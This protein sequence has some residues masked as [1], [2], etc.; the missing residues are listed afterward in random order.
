MLLL[1]ELEVCSASYVSSESFDKSTE[2][3]GAVMRSISWPVA[4][5]NVVYEPNQPTIDS[6][7]PGLRYL[8]KKLHQVDIIDLFPKMQLQELIYGRLEQDR[9]VHRDG[10]DARDAV[11]A[12]LPAPRDGFIHKVVHHEKKRLHLRARLFDM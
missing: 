9:V 4:V 6:T 8:V 11:V 5:C 10:P 1:I 12:L 7:N 2:S 3:S